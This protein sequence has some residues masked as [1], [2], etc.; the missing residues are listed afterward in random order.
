MFFVFCVLIAY[1]S[2]SMM[3]FMKLYSVR[4]SVR[5]QKNNLI[6]QLFNFQEDGQQRIETTNA[7]KTAKTASTI[8][9]RH[10]VEN[11]ESQKFAPRKNLIIFSPG[12]GGSS[13]LGALFDSNT[14]V[15]FWFEP[16]RIVTQKV[17]EAGVILKGNELINIRETC[18]NLIDSFFKCNFI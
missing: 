10:M 2:L 6:E 17:Y 16:L 12:R 7:E 9:I 14:Q 11:I 5:G 13:F 15:M 8:E 1:I 18:I 3:L 4:P